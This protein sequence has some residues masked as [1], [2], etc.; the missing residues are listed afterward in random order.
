MAVTTMWEVVAAEGQVEHLLDWVRQRLAPSAQLYR[1]A[2]GQARV[3][4]IDP[5]GQA[6]VALA[7]CPES[8]LQRPPHAWD[9]DRL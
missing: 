9:F 5:T 7:D 4:V 2:D 8:L 6:R 3:V 1:S